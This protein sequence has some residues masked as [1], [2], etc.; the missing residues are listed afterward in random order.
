MLSTTTKRVEDFEEKFNQ[1]GELAF[2]HRH[3][4]TYT[5]FTSAYTNDNNA[6]VGI[7]CMGE[8]NDIT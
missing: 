2:N 7:E 3:C 6:R 5:D 4:I 8:T 1:T